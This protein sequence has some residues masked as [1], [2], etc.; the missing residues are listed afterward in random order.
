MCQ[1][2]QNYGMKAE[3]SSFGV[4]PLGRATRVFC[5]HH[6]SATRIDTFRCFPND[7]ALVED[8]DLTSVNDIGIYKFC[9]EEAEWLWQQ[10]NELCTGDT[11]LR[12]Q[13]IITENTWSFLAN[14]YHF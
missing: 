4:T 12:N 3:P 9:A 10:N 2:L 5:R 6:S 14:G 1:L 13:L 8:F 11:L 7:K